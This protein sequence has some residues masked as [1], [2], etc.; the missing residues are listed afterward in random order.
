PSRQG[1]S[2]YSEGPSTELLEELGMQPADRPLNLKQ[3]FLVKFDRFPSPLIP[4]RALVHRS[5]RAGPDATFAESYPIHVS[6][7]GHILTFFFLQSFFQ[8]SL[9]PV[10]W[11]HHAPSTLSRQD[12]PR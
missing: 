10:V 5:C 9:A 12:P 11:S 7:G 3:R 6:P 1:G 8:H 2:I 4:S